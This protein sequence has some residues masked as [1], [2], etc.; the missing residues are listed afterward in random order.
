MN[1]EFNPDNPDRIFRDK[2][3]NWEVTPSDKVWDDILGQ[4]TPIKSAFSWSKWAS[5]VA[6]VLLL[7]TSLF[8]GYSALIQPS[9]FTKLFSGKKIKIIVPKNS[10]SVLSNSV[11]TVTLKENITPIEKINRPLKHNNLQA[12]NHSPSKSDL[13][14]VPQLI[15]SKEVDKEYLHKIPTYLKSILEIDNELLKRIDVNNRYQIENVARESLLGNHIKG[16]HIGGIYKFHSK[17]ILYQNTYER[18]KEYKL[19][20]KAGWGSAYGLS[21]GYDFSH[22]FGVQSEFIFNSSQGQKYED[23]IGK[24]NV[25]REVDLEYSQLQLL[26]KYKVSKMT[27]A[28]SNPLVINYIF[29]GSVGMLKSATETVD[30][31]NYDIKERFKK[32]DYSL[33]LGIDYDIYLNKHIFANIGTRGSISLLNINSKG[34]EIKNGNY[35]ASHN[36]LIG[37][38]GGLNYRF[39]K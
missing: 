25:K 1:H 32:Y 14:S 31:V 9:F 37:V 16:F 2:L 6:A 13:E 19:A 34:W 24:K 35:K 8:A 12:V 33:V 4:L 38:T 29:G 10:N 7:V 17:W 28:S 22:S 39:G 27:G 15:N 23:I 3:K 21:L 30:E 18:F 36:M 5:R 11:A 20:Y 26:L